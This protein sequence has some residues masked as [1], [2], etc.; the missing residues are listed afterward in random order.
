[1]YLKTK[2]RALNNLFGTLFSIQVCGGGRG[3]MY[4]CIDSLK[5]VGK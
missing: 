3:G 1:M 2:H 5:H 4:V